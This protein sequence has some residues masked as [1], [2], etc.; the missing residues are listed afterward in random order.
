MP[1]YQG[2]TKKIFIGGIAA[3]TM[4]E[5]I[6]HYFSSYGNVQDVVLMIDK[7]SQRPR[8]WKYQ[9]FCRASSK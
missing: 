8:G 1:M 4:K 2:D 5:D 7:Q 9:E 6:E 3:G